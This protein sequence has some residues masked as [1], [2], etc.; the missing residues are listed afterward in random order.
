MNGSVRLETG[1]CS[2]VLYSACVNLS[3]IELY[4]YLL[5]ENSIESKPLKACLSEMFP[6]ELCIERNG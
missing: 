6:G 1:P 3:K 5:H 4:Q 2:Q